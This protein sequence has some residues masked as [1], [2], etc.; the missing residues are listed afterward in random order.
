MV[1]DD[2]RTIWEHALMNELSLALSP[3]ERNF[4]QYLAVLI[5]ADLFDRREVR[6]MINMLV[7]EMGFAGIMVIQVVLLVLQARVSCWV[8]VEHADSA[9]H[10][11]TGV[12]VC[13]IWIWPCVGLCG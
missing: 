10:E 2:L 7:H 13:S 5:V 11:P 6:E 9:V 4:S 8:L 12:G 3:R 1:L